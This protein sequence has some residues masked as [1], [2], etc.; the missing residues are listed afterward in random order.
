MGEKTEPRPIEQN[1]ALPRLSRFFSA[2]SEF[3]CLINSKGS[4]RVVR[5]PRSFQEFVSAAAVAG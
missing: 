1:P 4:N 2:L 3:E 5:N